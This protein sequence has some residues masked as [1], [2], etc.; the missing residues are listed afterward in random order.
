ML[1]V[2]SVLCNFTLLC[3]RQVLP[4]HLDCVQSTK[5]V[6]GIPVGSCCASTDGWLSCCW[7]VLYAKDK[8]VDLT[9]AS[10]CHRTSAINGPTSNF[11]AINS[12]NDAAF[13]V[14]RFEEPENV[15]ASKTCLVEPR[16]FPTFHCGTR[17][18]SAY[19]SGTLSADVICR[20]YSCK[21]LLSVRR[22]LAFFG[23]R[24][25]RDKTIDVV[26]DRSDCRRTSAFSG[27]PSV[28]KR[29]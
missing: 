10:D 7:L 20:R 24:T 26:V 15:K 17:Q 13:D 2:T 19:R 3:A 1:G 29:P 14:W 22:W 5:S 21:S 4:T 28:P 11:L 27:L 25:R 18:G 8:V 12:E 6:R 9:A 16:F 23:C